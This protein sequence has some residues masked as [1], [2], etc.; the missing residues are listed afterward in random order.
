MGDSCYAI[1]IINDNGV[2]VV[3]FATSKNLT[4]KS[5][6]FPHCNIH[7]S[8]LDIWWEDAQSID[9]ILFWGSSWGAAQ[10]AAPQEGL[11]SVSKQ[12]C[13]YKQVS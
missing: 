8:Y 12:V 2:R 4:V 1:V 9:H 10:L 13:V 6:M 7:I 5:T 3:N 11:S